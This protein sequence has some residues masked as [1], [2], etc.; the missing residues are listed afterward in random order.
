MNQILTLLLCIAMTLSLASCGTKS[1]PAVPEGS[2]ADSPIS[3]E[4]EADPKGSASILEEES[5]PESG[6]IDFDDI[7]FTEV[8][9]STYD[10]D[11][12]KLV[13]CIY[14]EPTV[15]MADAAVQEKIQ[16]ALDEVIGGL[17]DT[18]SF[19]T[20]M[21]QEEYASRDQ[22]DSY[23]MLDEEGNYLPY[24]LHMSGR[25]TR[26]DDQVI[27]IVIDESMYTHGAHGGTNR[28][29]CNF[30]AQ[31]GEYLSFEQ[32]GE[33]FR[34]K[35]EE[36]VLAKAD[37]MAANEEDCPFY[38]DYADSIHLVVIDGTESS[39]DVWGSELGDA[40]TLAG[41]APTFYFSQDGLVFVSNEYTLQ[42]YAAGVIEFEIPYADF[43]DVLNS[44]YIPF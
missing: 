33:D 18:C 6:D 41:V 5:F 22:E 1:V 30:D 20:E 3:S 25:V 35:A 19:Y 36:L 42:A 44:N 34:T 29:G 32:L 27:S 16:Q 24:Y 9:A 2:E 23:V 8:D 7:A 15:T 12:T 38:P 21:S 11:G 4:E 43:G 40:D 13:D 37:E 17:K 28:F 39:L 26:D 14:M 31:T 10:E